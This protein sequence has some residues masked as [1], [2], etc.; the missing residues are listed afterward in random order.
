MKNKIAW[1]APEFIHYPKSVWWFAVIA[2]AGTGLVIY[3]LFEKNFMT[4]T[5]FVLLLVMTFFYAKK[6]P[7]TWRIELG[8]SGLKLS[9]MSIPYGQIKNFWIV[10]EPPEVK[11]LNFET[12]AR[13]NRYITLQL[14]NQNP[15][16]IRKFLLEYLPEDLEREEQFADKLARTFKF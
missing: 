2:I 14:M 16:E 10:Y 11:T 9:N 15:V 4:A 8:G 3:F 1:E 13:I 7:K 5:L 12:T 6:K